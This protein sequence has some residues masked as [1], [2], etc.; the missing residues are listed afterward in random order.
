M[1]GHSNQFYD[2]GGFYKYILQTM[3]ARTLKLYILH[4]FA[5]IYGTIDGFPDKILTRVSLW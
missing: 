4:M 5:K 3:E 2:A 1:F